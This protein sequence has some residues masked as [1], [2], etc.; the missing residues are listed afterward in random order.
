MATLNDLRAMPPDT[1]A[2]KH[3]FESVPH[4]F[5]GDLDAYIAWKADLGSR[6]DVDPRAIALVGSSMVG[7]SLNPDK[8]FKQFDADSDIDVAVV[9]DHHFDSAWRLLRTAHASILTMPVEAQNAI[10]RHRKGYVF[11][12]AIATDFVLAYLPFAGAWLPAF[13]HMGTIAPTSGFD[14]KARIYRDFDC[15][16]AYQLKGIKHAQASLTND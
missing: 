7:I 10:R 14:V 3:V 15:L 12:G 16:R 6:I 4:V 11:D 13:S 8:N 9:S 1:F 2:S 5:A